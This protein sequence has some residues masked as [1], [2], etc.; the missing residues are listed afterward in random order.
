[1]QCHLL[2]VQALI[3][4]AVNPVRM[5]KHNESYISIVLYGKSKMPMQVI[6]SIFLNSR[7]SIGI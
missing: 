4:G 7:E 6:T 3:C 1:M 5:T 2:D